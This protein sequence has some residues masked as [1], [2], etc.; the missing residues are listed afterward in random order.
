MPQLNRVANVTKS[1]IAMLKVGMAKE[2]P[3]PTDGQFADL[4]KALNTVDQR[5]RMR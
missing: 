3:V 2:F 5:Q 1:H 4:L